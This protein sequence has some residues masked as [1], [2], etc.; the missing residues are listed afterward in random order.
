MGVIPI[1]E[2]NPQPPFLPSG[3]DGNSPVSSSTLSLSLKRKEA[4][5]A[6]VL[7]SPVHP[8]PCTQHSPPYSSVLSLRTLGWSVSH[9]VRSPSPPLVKKQCSG[10]CDSLSESREATSTNAIWGK[11]HSLVASLMCRLTQCIWRFSWVPI[12]PTMSP[13]FLYASSPT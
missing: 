12:S 11:R 6:T 3:R 9:K 2:K 7:R 13:C 8:L 4:E 1:A 5:V 10:V